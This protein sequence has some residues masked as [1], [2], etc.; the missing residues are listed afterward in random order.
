MPEAKSAASRTARPEAQVATAPMIS[1][2][3][4]SMSVCLMK[5]NLASFRGPCGKARYPGRWSRHRYQLL[6]RQR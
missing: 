1:P 2:L 5:Q 6:N 3:R 4:L